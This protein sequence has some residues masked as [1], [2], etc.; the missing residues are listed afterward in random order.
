MKRQASDEEKTL[1]KTAVEQTRPQ[2]IVKPKTKKA[3][4]KVKAGDM[5][6]G[7]EFDSISVSTVKRLPT[8]ALGNS[9]PA[10]RPTKSLD[11]N[12]RQRLKRG[13]K[14]P[15]ARMDLHGLTQEAAHR[16]LLA[17]LRRAPQGRDKVDIGDHRQRQSQKRRR[18]QMDDART[19]RAQG[20]G[21]ALA[22]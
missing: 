22:E 6:R 15:E 21:A 9:G 1:F 19:W 18:R 16:A 11:G 10:A 8:L 3:V 20:N 2:V 13:A 14:E 7:Q 5:E 17:F 12:T 4:G